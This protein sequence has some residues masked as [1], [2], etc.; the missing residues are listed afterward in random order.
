M[1]PPA[2]ESIKTPGLSLMATEGSMGEKR[3][4]QEKS[5]SIIRIEHLS[6]VFS[7]HQVVVAVDDVSFDVMQGEIFGLLGPNGAGKSTLIRILTTLMMPTSGRAIVDVYDVTKDQEKVRGVIGVCPQN[8]SLDLELSAYDNL[9]FFGRLQNLNEDTIK[10]RVW[11]LLEMVGLSDRADAKVST[12]SGG[13]RRK[14]EIVRAFIH[15]PLLLFLDEPTIGLDP[16]SRREVWRQISLLNTE[17]TTI[18]LTTHYMDEAEKLCDR[19]AFMDQGR[20]IALDTLKQLQKTIPGGEKIEV[21]FV[22][23]ND[24]VIDAIKSHPEV[25]GVEV[26]G[27]KVHISSQ[28]GTSLL[29]AILDDFERYS[30]G[31]TTLSIRHPS[32]E[33]VF[34]HLTGKDFGERDAPVVG[35][36]RRVP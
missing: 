21:G 35:P 27:G 5:R 29:P 11:E 15:R 8:S 10:R 31:V 30:I 18:I 17:N 20:L 23:F 4:D 2:Q 12:F 33:D 13:M 36:S 22:H 9:D 26:K 32:L 16:E 28:Q 25:R 3:P 14:L 7:A 19:I 6:K 24:A 1:P 34:I